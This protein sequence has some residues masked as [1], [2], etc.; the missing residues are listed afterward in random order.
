MEGG[1]GVG[2]GLTDRRASGLL[3]ADVMVLVMKCCVVS[4]LLL[5]LLNADGA[6]VV[7]MVV[8]WCDVGWTAQRGQTKAY[9]ISRW[10]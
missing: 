6:W 9:R 8:V 1:W 2:C 7:W 3:L 4:L 5:L 10:C